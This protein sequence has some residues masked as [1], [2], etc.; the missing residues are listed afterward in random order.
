MLPFRPFVAGLLVVC[1]SSCSLGVGKHQNVI[2]NSNVPASLIVNGTPQGTTPQ[3]VKAQ[4]NKTLALVAT[5][6][7]YQPATKSVDRQ[8]SSTGMLDIVGGLF[9]GLPFLGL[10]S[11]G[12]WELE[13]SNIFLHLEKK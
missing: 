7:G 11:A 5:A 1:L 8:I 3:T 2:I 13:E 6:P 10:L 9:I 12:A 4:R